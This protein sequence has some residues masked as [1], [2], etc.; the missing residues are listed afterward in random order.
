MRSLSGHH[1]YAHAIHE[2]EGEWRFRTNHDLVIASHRSSGRTCTSA[3]QPTNE[4]A[5]AAPGQT[6]D[7]RTGAGPAADK[8]RGTLAFTF[9]SAAP[10]AGVDRH[11]SSVDPQARQTQRKFAFTFEFAT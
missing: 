6:A 10:R 4:R 2:T 7:E 5:F 11:A 3:G 8:A 9:E 1:L